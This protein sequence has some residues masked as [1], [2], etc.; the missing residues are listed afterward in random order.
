M[1]AAAPCDARDGPFDHTFRVDYFSWSGYLAQVRSVR[2]K[3]VQAHEPLQL[4][5]LLLSLLTSVRFGTVFGSESNSCAALPVRC[6]DD[7]L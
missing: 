4:F 3:H 5:F 6:A 2:P 1:P 7:G